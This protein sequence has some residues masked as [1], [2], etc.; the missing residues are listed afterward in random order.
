M[1]VPQEQQAPWGRAA[2]AR[3]MQVLSADPPIRGQMGHTDHRSF[4]R[5][6]LRE[7]SG[8]TEKQG[9][10][11]NR[12]FQQW[13]ETCTQEADRR[14]RFHKDESELRG[15]GRGGKPL[16][17]ALSLS[18]TSQVDPGLQQD[19]LGRA[20]GGRPQA[21]PRVR[22]PSLTCASLTRCAPAGAGTSLSKDW[23]KCAES[24]GQRP[25]GAQLSKESTAAK[26]WGP[27]LHGV[28]KCPRVSGERGCAEAGRHLDTYDP[29][30]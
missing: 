20:T 29:S 1:K 18:L 30:P 13:G 17:P 8:T 15:G 2:V 27:R 7:G 12:G 9:S 26:P 6:E 23:R 28:T 16:P 22:C 4:S 5:T 11:Q 19:L 25:R 14:A 10:V 3:A 21:E 24:S